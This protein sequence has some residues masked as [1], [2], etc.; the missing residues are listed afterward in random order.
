VVA[1]GL[2][3]EVREARDDVGANMAEELLRSAPTLLLG[4]NVCSTNFLPETSAYAWWTMQGLKSCLK[5]L[6]RRVGLQS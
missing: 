1:G 2:V 4:R 6:R 5:M 3:L